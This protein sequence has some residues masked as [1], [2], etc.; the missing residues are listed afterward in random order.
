MFDNK[1]LITLLG[2][3]VAV[4]AV[5]KIKSQEDEEETMEEF[6]MNPSRQ[7]KAD[8]VEEIKGQMYSVPGTYQALL[9]PRFS[10]V[11]YGANVRY[12]MPSVKNQAVPCTPLTFASMASKGGQNYVENFQQKDNCSS[13]SCGGGGGP[14]KCGVGGTSQ[15]YHGGAPLTEPGYGNGN[16][17]N[18]LD[19][20]YSGDKPASANA[21]AH[22][23]L[24]VNDMT[25]MDAA[26]E[27]GEGQVFTY[28]RYIYA[29]RNSRLRS[30]GDP[31]R[32]DLPVVPCA[33]GWFR[34]SVT[35]NI[36]LQQGAM[37]VLGGS[38]MG[39]NN[40]LAN[41]IYTSSGNSQRVISG[42]D[43][44][45]TQVNTARAIANGVNPNI[46]MNMGT[47]YG[48][49]LSSAAQSSVTVTAFP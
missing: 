23:M 39:T 38:N 2:L 42:I 27:R 9:S 19:Q 37:F 20:V 14:I 10:N 49:G 48:G 6:W 7:V 45:N 12:N 18:V 47:Q 8:V 41:L 26:A 31:I 17:N 28:D 16:Y 40:D 24:P 30:Q 4:V 13:G 34:P 33:G 5:T 1:F 25:S 22:G 36:D 15:S 32:G 29:N 11:D 44:D 3:I 21:P 43:M 46:G 35:P